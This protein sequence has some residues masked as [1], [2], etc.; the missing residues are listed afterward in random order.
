MVI[1]TQA[2]ILAKCASEA[3]NV[4]IIRTY[5]VYFDPPLSSVTFRDDLF[6]AAMH[7]KVVIEQHL[8]NCEEH[9]ENKK[10]FLALC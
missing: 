7:A 10:T 4:Q 2:T 9:F 8:I 3:N 5:G 1:I 6:D